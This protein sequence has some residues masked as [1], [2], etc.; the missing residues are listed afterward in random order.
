MLAKR[1]LKHQ[2]AGPLRPG[3][4]LLM[5]A[6]LSRTCETN[7]NQTGYQALTRTSCCVNISPRQWYNY[8]M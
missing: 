1:S 3:R 2:A 5:S 4:A 8:R 7:S 6:Y